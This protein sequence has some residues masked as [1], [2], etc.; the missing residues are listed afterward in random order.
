MTISGSPSPVISLIKLNAK[1]VAPHGYSLDSY[2][3]FISQKS[4]FFY[5][6]MPLIFLTQ[7]KYIYRENFTHDTSTVY[8]LSLSVH[9]THSSK[10]CNITSTPES[11]FMS[12]S[13]DY[14]HSSMVTFLISNSAHALVCTLNKQD[15]KV[16][17]L[18]LNS[19]FVR[20]IYVFIGSFNLLS[21]MAP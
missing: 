4:Y 12:P 3:R 17:I 8:E 21:L 20:F 16:Y 9:R 7:L 18:P 2:K 13:G 14:N 19:V 5:L 11:H 6:I 10:K 1:A 15:H